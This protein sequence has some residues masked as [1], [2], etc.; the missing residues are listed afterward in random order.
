M[1]AEELVMARRA[2]LG[3]HEA[4]EHIYTTYYKQI[5]WHITRIVRDPL[6]AE[7]LTQEVFLKAYQFMGTYSG[8]A[9]L[10]RWLRK[11]ATNTCIDRMRKKTVPTVSWPTLQSK[12]G[13]EQPVEFPD[14]SPSPLDM[15]ESREGEDAILD[16]IQRLPE[17]YRKVVVLYDVMEKTGE[18]VAREAACPIGTVKSRLSRAHGILRS[19]LRPENPALAMAPAGA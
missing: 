7:D 9:N 16:E 5:L 17:Y 19:A 18:E 8:T 15:T 14:D 1:I 2:S 6:D 11:I 3:D 10:G 4:F 13:D 12:D